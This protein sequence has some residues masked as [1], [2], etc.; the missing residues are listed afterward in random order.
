MLKAVR[1]VRE[2]YINEKNFAVNEIFQYSEVLLVNIG[3]KS[4]NKSNDWLIG[5]WS[6]MTCV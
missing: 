6:S 4:R 5:L 2:L 1:N 3:I